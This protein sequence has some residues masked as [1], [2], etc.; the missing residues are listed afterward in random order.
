MLRQK[1]Y[2]SHR[3]LG[4]LCRIQRPGSSF[5]LQISGRFSLSNMKK[6]CAIAI[7]AVI[8]SLPSGEASGEASD[9]MSGRDVASL[10]QLGTAAL[11]VLNKVLSYFDSGADPTALSVQQTYDMV[12][13]LHNRLN[14]HGVV[15]EA[16]RRNTDSMTELIDSMPVIIRDEIRRETE[17]AFAQDRRRSIMGIVKTIK[18]DIKVKEKNGKPVANAGLRLH[19][20]QIKTRALMER[21]SEVDIPY[22]VTA[23]AVELGLIQNLN[24]PEHGSDATKTDYDV[25]KRRYNDYLEKIIARTLV[26]RYADV[27]NFLYDGQRKISH[28]SDVFSGIK[29][30]HAGVINRLESVSATISRAQG[31]LRRVYKELKGAIRRE[32]IYVDDVILGKAEIFDKVG[33]D[34][35]IFGT[36]GIIDFFEMGPQLNYLID[37]LN[38]LSQEENRLRKECYAISEQLALVAD[39]TYYFSFNNQTTVEV[40]AD[41]LD[42]YVERARLLVETIHGVEKLVGGHR[43]SVDLYMRELGLGSGVQKSYLFYMK[44]I[45]FPGRAR[46]WRQRVINYL[47]HDPCS[48]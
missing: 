25:R 44:Y 34:D 35:V 3:K 2:L 46:L 5:G 9:G 19:D 10:V 6:W 8:L 26:P 38:R 15:L 21:T 14:E 41:D 7:C 37:R 28:R 40:D 17:S 22:I 11:N 13:Q 20:L 45:G 48:H 33:I 18:E 30:E 39:I 32:G 43:R 23:M 12:T 4:A 42:S 1:A 31:E 47:N 16:I 27:I 36:V 24:F 29:A